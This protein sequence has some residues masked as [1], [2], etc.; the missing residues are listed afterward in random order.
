MKALCS[1]HTSPGRHIAS[2]QDT[3]KP[4]AAGKRSSLCR[5]PGFFGFP[6]FQSTVWGSVL[7]P[8]VF[9]AAIAFSGS[10]LPNCLQLALFSRSRVQCV[11]SNLTAKNSTFVLH[12]S[13]TACNLYAENKKTLTV[14]RKLTTSNKTQKLSLIWFCPNT[15]F[16]LPF[17]FSPPWAL[18]WPF[19]IQQRSFL[20]QLLFCCSIS[21]LCPALLK[22]QPSSLVCAVLCSFSV[23]KN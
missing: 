21:P 11:I 9:A 7:I 12:C 20:K 23:W 10:T 4:D 22:P 6:I 5:L 3:A 19:L 2:C 8:P 17:P 14:C 1:P 16:H 13:I 18:L 15:S